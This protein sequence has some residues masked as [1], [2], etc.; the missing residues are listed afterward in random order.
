LEEKAAS[1]EHDIKNNKAIKKRA[2]GVKRDAP[3]A[4]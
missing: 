2:E 1:H 3:G 4:H